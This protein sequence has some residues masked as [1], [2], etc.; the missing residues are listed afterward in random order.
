VIQ[1]NEDDDDEILSTSRR[2]TSKRQR[3]HRDEENEDEEE[4][5]ELV[6]NNKC[7]QCDSSFT[8]MKRLNEHVKRKHSSQADRTCIHCAK[9]LS[10][11]GSI[12]HHTKICPK[13]AA[14]TIRCVM[15]AT[16]SVATQR[17]PTAPHRTTKKSYHAVERYLVAVERI[18]YRW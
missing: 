2:H 7:A 10:N 17:S 15:M 6:H 5:T 12:P 8:T 1:Y 16:S 14:V 9:V 18:S 13:R 4:E 11:A 3:Q